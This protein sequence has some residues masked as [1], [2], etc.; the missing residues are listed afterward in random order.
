MT[1]QG[2]S[3][4]TRLQP[5]AQQPWG[6]PASIHAWGQRA[7]IALEQARMQVAALINA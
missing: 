3:E 4:A 7:A 5:V 6:I 1:A 2:K